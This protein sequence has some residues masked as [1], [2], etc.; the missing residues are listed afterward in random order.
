MGNHTSTLQI[1]K[2]PVI[3]AVELAARATLRHVAVRL[4][5]D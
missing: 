2:T 1:C 4:I 5:S 3:A